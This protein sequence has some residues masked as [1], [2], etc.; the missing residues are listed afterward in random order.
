MHIYAN[1]LHIHALKQTR[2]IHAKEL[3]NNNGPHTARC[4]LRYRCDVEP[5]TDGYLNCWGRG[6]T[7]LEL[8]R[9]PFVMV[10]DKGLRLLHAKE[11]ERGIACALVVLA[12]ALQ[13]LPA[14]LAHIGSGLAIQARM[15]A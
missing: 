8:D 7:L 3:T 6:R 15:P 5:D 1:L 14:C 11:D 13:M 2:H 9:H 12:Q 4:T 10:A